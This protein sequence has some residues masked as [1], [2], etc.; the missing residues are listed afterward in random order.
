MKENGH[1]LHDVEVYNYYSPLQTRDDTSRANFLDSLDKTL[2]DLA[3]ASKTTDNEENGLYTLKKHLPVILRLSYDIPFPDVRE[4]CTRILQELEDK[5]VG[6]PRTRYAGPTCFISSKELIPVDT[7]DEEIFIH[8][9][10]AFLYSGRVTNIKRIM[11][12]HL[13]YL[14]AFM[15]TESYLMQ[16]EGPLPF[17]WRCYIG[18][19]AAAR[20]QCQYLVNI[21]ETEFLLQNG[22]PDWLK[23]IDHAPKKL[24]NLME[25]N[26]ILAHRPWLITV[27]H[28]Q[29]L[30]KGPSLETW[31]V[32]ELVHAIVILVH[33]HGVAGFVYGC[34]V[35]P[36]IDMEGGHTFIT[37]SISDSSSNAE[38]TTP[39]SNAVNCFKQLQTLENNTQTL[40][41]RMKQVEKEHEQEEEATQEEVLRQ[42]RSVENGELALAKE[43]TVVPEVAPNL[44]RYRPDRAFRYEDFAKRDRDSGMNPFRAQ[45]FSWHKHGYSLVDRLYPNIGGLLDAKFNAIVSLTY[46][47]MGD[48]TDV[49][50]SIFRLATW[51][52][53]HLVYGIFHDDY[54]YDEVNQLLYRPYKEYVKMVACFP[55]KVTQHDYL[56]F[57][58]LKHS[59]KVHI[60]LLI[61]ES[62]MQAELLYFL[63]ILSNYMK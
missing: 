53:I 24:Q 48:T 62:R 3:D 36:E 25:V 13:P 19:L 1:K 4:Y 39:T 31:S 17:D 34:G 35:N 18:I 33:Y 20:H 61:L 11:S 50:T 60:N 12:F 8:F 5:G 16:G 29:S 40:L 23:G 28:L 57:L 30:L 46:K 2:K 54:R 22:D 10:D 41:E 44:D 32:A 21:C 14:D 59:E 47:T 26:K 52:Y 51:N 43:E 58:D 45:D 38:P 49:D 7:D 56:N 15:S 63:R 6:V 9:S 42:F 55:E 27:E 37:P